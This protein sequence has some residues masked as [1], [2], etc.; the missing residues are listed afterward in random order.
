MIRPE[1][2]IK[3]IKHIIII[4]QT[5]AEVMTNI[6]VR[7]EKSFHRNVNNRKMF[8]YYKK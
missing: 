4:T 6:T 8:F 5:R 3:N 7:G 2:I 1:Y